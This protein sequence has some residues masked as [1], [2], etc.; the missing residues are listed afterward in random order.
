[1]NPMLVTSKSL[2]TYIYLSARCTDLPVPALPQDTWAFSP[3]HM[4]PPRTWRSPAKVQIHSCVS[5]IERILGVSSSTVSDRVLYL[6][7][8]NIHLPFL[9]VFYT[10]ST[11]HQCLLKLP[12]HYCLA[13][14]HLRSASVE[15]SN[16]FSP[17]PTLMYSLSIG[18][19]NT[20]SYFCLDLR[21]NFRPLCI[22]F[23]CS[24]FYIYILVDF[25]KLWDII[26]WFLTRFKI[27]SVRGKLEAK[28]GRSFSYT[29]FLLLWTDPLLGGQTTVSWSQSLGFFFLFMRQ[30]LCSRLTSDQ[31]CRMTFDF[32]ITLS[33]HPGAGITC[34]HHSTHCWRWSLEPCACCARMLST[35]LHPQCSIL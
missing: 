5:Q 15:E 2:T 27:N 33:H 17:K 19:I 26:Y 1:M 32:W 18:L 25:I 22:F 34:A 20:A 35:E 13:C 31:I 8:K 14:H 9:G 4:R 24:H 16:H 30:I 3:T 7:I 21:F 11:W 6:H 29:V 10:P 28:T 23:I 12:F